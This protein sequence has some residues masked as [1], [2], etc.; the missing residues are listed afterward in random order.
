VSETR[1]I[2][3]PVYRSPDVEPTCARDFKTGEGCQ[4]LRVGGIYGKYEFCA[5]AVGST[6]YSALSRRAA[7]DG[8]PGTGYLIPSPDCPLWREP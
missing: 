1:T 6:K 5:L 7:P 4:L 8:T 3:L 2:T